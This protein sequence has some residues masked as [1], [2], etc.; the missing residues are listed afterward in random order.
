MSYVYMLI[1][2]ILIIYLLYY[3]YTIILYIMDIIA[4]EG[5]L[6]LFPGLFSST[7]FMSTFSNN[8]H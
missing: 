4:Y 1:H 2:I 3:I 6:L 8:K 7:H 5:L